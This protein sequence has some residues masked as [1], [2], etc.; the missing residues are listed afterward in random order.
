M[1]PGR[2]LHRFASF[3]C[4]TTTREQIVEP[5]LSDLQHQWIDDSS[6]RA[7]TLL[8]GYLAFWQTLA[9]CGWRAGWHSL[10]TAPSRITFERIFVWAYAIG[11]VLVIVF[12]FAWVRTGTLDSTAGMIAIRKLTVTFG[13][14]LFLSHYWPRARRPQTRALV[15][16]AFASAMAVG[17]W[18][19][20]DL[21]L[22]PVLYNL[23]YLPLVWNPLAW[24]V[25]RF[26]YR[27]PRSV[28]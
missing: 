7:N 14:G 3:W 27:R 26:H 11:I 2:W 4:D 20:S 16:F 9:L 19:D 8:R 21:R 12:G 24:A 5:L 10:L 25:A 6:H 1:I 18:I 22:G 13:P 15:L 17:Y 23:L 28:K